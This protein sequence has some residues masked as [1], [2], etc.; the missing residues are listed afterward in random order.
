MISTL[1]T[2]FVLPMLYILFER[3]FPYF[4][5]RAMKGAM[6]VLLIFSASAANGQTKI[7]TRITLDQALVRAVQNNPGIEALRLNEQY[8]QSLIQ[9]S[10]DL[11]KTNADF[12][13]GKINGLHNDNRFSVSQSLDFPTVYSKSKKVQKTNYEISKNQTKLREVELKAEVKD[14]Y[15]KL[16]L[17]ESKSEVL[18]GADSIYGRYFEKAEQRFKH[19]EAD[20]LEKTTGENQ[21]L[22]IA[23]QLRALHV[24]EQALLK[25]LRLLI[26]T[27]EHVAPASVPIIYTPTLSADTSGLMNTPSMR[28]QQ[29]E[30]L[31]AEQQIKVERDKLLPSINLGYNNMSIQGWQTGPSGTEQYF[32]RNKRFSSIEVGVG[33]PVF[34]MAQRARVQASKFQRLQREKE[35]QSYKSSLTTGL[36]NEWNNYTQLREQEKMYQAQLLPNAEAIIK[37]ATERLN[38]GEIDYLNWVILIN[39]S[40][41]IRSQYLD[42]VEQLNNSAIEIERL[43]GTH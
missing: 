32:D 40:I 25:R 18:L 8:S 20:I 34:S 43:N 11:E 23:A 1:L 28:L 14:V 30:V 7:E 5:S 38:A 15:Y 10:F 24:E 12:E 9:T 35:L 6:A 27:D 4:K 3:G 33:I 31:L 37:A 41:E 13:Y 16:L 36:M 17:L 26:N 21:R 2:L 39:Q 42:L 19:G 22:Q 29:N